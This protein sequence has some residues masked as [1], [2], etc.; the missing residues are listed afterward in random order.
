[1]IDGVDNDYINLIT[2]FQALLNHPAG[3]DHGSSVPSTRAFC[4]PP[5]DL[6][7][8]QGKS[9]EHTLCTFSED[10]LS[11]T[12]QANRILYRR[13]M[14]FSMATER[15]RSSLPSPLTETR[16]HH[17]SSIDSSGNSV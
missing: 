6:R 7:I 10:E 14:P 2:I 11:A 17:S 1:M 5:S 12:M 16:K 13:S 3:L 8:S 15:R 9:A 4:S